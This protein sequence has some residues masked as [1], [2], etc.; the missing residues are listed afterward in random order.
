RS[1]AVA[2]LPC[3][4]RPA[5]ALLPY[6]SCGGRSVV[7]LRDLLLHLGCSTPEKSLRAF[8][9]LGLFALHIPRS[10]VKNIQMLDFIVAGWM[11]SEA[12]L[13][14][15]PALTHEGG[16]SPFSPPRQGVTRTVRNLRESDGLEFLLRVAALWQRVLQ[17]P[18]KLTMEGELF[19]RE[20]E[21]LA[22]DPALQSPQ[23]D[24]LVPIPD[25]AALAVLLGQHLGLFV[26]DRDASL[27]RSQLS[28]V[29]QES[30]AAIQ[31]RVWQ[32]LLFTRQWKEPGVEQEEFFDRRRLPA[33]RLATLLLLA[34]LEPDTWIGLTALDR[35]VSSCT[36]D[37]PVATPRRGSKPFRVVVGKVAEGG[38][39]DEEQGEMMEWL[40]AFVLGVMYQ[41]GAVHV[42]QDADTGTRLVRLSPLGRWLMKVG[43]QPPPSPS[44]EKTLFVQ[45]NHEVVVYRQGLTPELIGQLA[46]FCRWK[47]LG[48]ALMLELTAESV[49]CGL[50]LGRTAEEMINILELHSQRPIPPG[51][52]DSIRTW[53]GRRERLQLYSQCTVLEFTSREDLDHAVARGVSGERLT[54]RLLLVAD[55]RTLPFHQFRLAPSRDYRLPPAVCVSAA[56]DGVTW[57][58]DLNRSDLMVESELARFADSLV[59]GSSGRLRYRITVDSLAKAARLGLRGPY[60]REWFR[61]R[62]GEDLPASVELMLQA[63]SRSAIQLARVFVV[64]VPN[65]AVAD[66]L[67]Q[68]PLTQPHIQTRLGPT[69]LAVLS[70]RVPALRAALQQLGVEIAG[71]TSH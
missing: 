5:L 55:E 43:E 47:S 58:V 16:K 63:S 56:N 34:A 38:P 24:E 67:M 64:Q 39:V 33:R 35:E 66:G 61:D 11:Q 69:A 18:L 13:V 23:F 1:L 59:D 15:H 51:V 49:Y 14:P 57:E 20:Q 2:D 21:R 37:R 4:A 8:L 46:S 12:M 71:Q 68:H 30:L 3:E 45:P 40:E 54:D 25:M 28:N 65:S 44:V 52:L 53:S 36:L 62:A 9:G 50:E 26:Q 41:L 32:A 27:L 19:K 31:R 6:V 48:A 22:A 60:L 17:T 7:D 10:P 42:A 70:E 29:W